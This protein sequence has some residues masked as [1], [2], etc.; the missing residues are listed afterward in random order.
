MAKKEYIGLTYEDNRLRMARVQVTKTG[1]ELI[2]VDTIDMPQPLYTEGESG[3]LGD[4]DFSE[5]YE[6]IFEMD[7]PSSES[8][9]EFDDLDLSLDEPEESTQQSNASDLEESFDMTRTEDE[10][11]IERDN[12][13]LLADYLSQYGKRKIRIGTHIPFGRTT[14]QVLKKVDPG[15]M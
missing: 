7:T 3:G 2:E 1:L 14:F 11:D 5:D 13:Q 6:E 9:R 12:E 10:A 4:L 15:S 8:T